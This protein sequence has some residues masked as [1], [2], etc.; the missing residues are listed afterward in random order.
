MDNQQEFDITPPSFS[1]IAARY[2]VFLGLGLIVIALL[3]K[4]GNFGNAFNFIWYI[5][6]FM[7][8]GIFICLHHARKTA[9]DMEMT[10]GKAFRFGLILTFFVAISLSIY[11]FAVTSFVDKEWITNSA[12]ETEE[13]IADSL[14]QLPEKYQEMMEESIAQM[15]ATKPLELAWGMLINVLILGLIL[16]AILAIFFKTKKSEDSF[17]SDLA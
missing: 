15:Y 9:F 1:K 17:E 8:G 6:L 5:G 12:V 7:L 16:S 2:G 11:V 13:K 14:D 10:Y 4:I 3:L